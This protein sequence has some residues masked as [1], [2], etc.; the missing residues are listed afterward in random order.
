MN[1]LLDPM[2]VYRARPGS[3]PGIRGGIVVTAIA[4]CCFVA[5]LVRIA[6]MSVLE[7]MEILA[8]AVVGIILYGLR[9]QKSWWESLEIGL[10]EDR[11]IQRARMAARSR[12]DVMRSPTSSR[13]RGDGW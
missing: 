2:R 13:D 10:G 1:K 4:L 9:R 12:S 8:P 5:A 6:V 11:I 7:G 3:W